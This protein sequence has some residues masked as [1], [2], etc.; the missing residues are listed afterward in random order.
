MHNVSIYTCVYVHMHDNLA[1]W[2]RFKVK[3]FAL[4]SVSV[5]ASF[6]VYIHGVQITEDIQGSM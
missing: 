2:R 6:Y 3:A 4:S 1:Y 5:Y